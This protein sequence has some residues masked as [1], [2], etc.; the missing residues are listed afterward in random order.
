[1]L[2]KTVISLILLLMVLFTASCA[3]I[4]ELG[5]TYSYFIPQNAHIADV[6]FDALWGDSDGVSAGIITSLGYGIEHFIRF[7]SNALI[8]GPGISV[9]P[10]VKVCI[11]EMVSALAS[12]Q[13]YG[14]YPLYPTVLRAKASAEMRLSLIGSLFAGIGAGV[15]YPEWCASLS[16]VCGVRL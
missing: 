16:L 13:L 14:A 8:A 4:G 15:L 1:M 5:A 7:G 2:R 9:G 11:N 12:V 10:E 3:F 6:R